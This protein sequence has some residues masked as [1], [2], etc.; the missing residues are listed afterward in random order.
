MFHS[1]ISEPFFVAFVLAS[2]LFSGQINIDSLPNLL[3]LVNPLWDRNLEVYEF[4]RS[5]LLRLWPQWKFGLLRYQEWADAGAAEVITRLR[6]G[7]LQLDS[8]SKHFEQPISL[9]HQ[10]G[11]P[12][13]FNRTRLKVGAKTLLFFCISS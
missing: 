5:R 1:E 3:D 12:N 4:V 8:Y 6:H 11:R 9:Q 2:S 7:D 13:M 10:F